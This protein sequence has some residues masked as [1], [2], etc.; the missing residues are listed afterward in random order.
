MKTTNNNILVYFNVEMY[1]YLVNEY[2]ILV[3]WQWTIING[4]KYLFIRQSRE[5]TEVCT[6]NEED[7]HKW[8]S[9]VYY[10]L[11]SRGKETHVVRIAHKVYLSLSNNTLIK[12]CI[13]R[14]FY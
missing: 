2:G 5:Q 10:V 14:K 3:F 6:Q 12:T 13:K 11:Y 1:T 7:Y 8:V 4:V 9:N